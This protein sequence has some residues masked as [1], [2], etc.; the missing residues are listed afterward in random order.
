MFSE[1][2]EVCIDYSGL[3]LTAPETSLSLMHFEDGEWID[4]TTSLDTINDIICGTVSS[5]SPFVIMEDLGLVELL[6]N[7]SQAVTDLN[8]QQGIDNSL[9]AKL[10]SALQALQDINQNNDVAA[11]NS[12]NAFIN[13]VLAQSGNQISMED[14]DQLIATAQA[15]MALLG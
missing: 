1:S 11:I 2:I 4:A 9:D 5:L 6:L 12:L 7:L 14:G 15:I 10:D 3:N 8:L 13:A